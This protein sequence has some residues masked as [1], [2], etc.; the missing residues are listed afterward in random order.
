VFSGWYSN[1]PEDD[2]EQMLG[3]FKIK[4][5]GEAEPSK[6]VKSSQ[7]WGVAFSL[8]EVAMLFAFLHHK[9]ELND[10]RTYI[11]QKFA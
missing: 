3:K 2:F 11:H 4:V 1:K 8:F 7:D 5:A 9:D 10:Y 6:M